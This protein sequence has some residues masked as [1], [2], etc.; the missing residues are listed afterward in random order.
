MANIINKLSVNGV[1]SAEWNLAREIA[2]GRA[3]VSSTLESEL[4][5]IYSLNGELLGT[6]GHFQLHMVPSNANL[7]RPGYIPGSARSRAW[8]GDHLAH[9][10]TIAIPCSN[11]KVGTRGDVKFRT[12]RPH[13]RTSWRRVSL[14]GIGGFEGGRRQCGRFIKACRK[15][16]KFLWSYG[17]KT[18]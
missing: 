15:A 10:C 8:A 17:N 11:P 6:V 5:C 7:V 18:K 1:G 9:V 14:L 16:G 2:E 4:G 13:Q 3:T 12:E